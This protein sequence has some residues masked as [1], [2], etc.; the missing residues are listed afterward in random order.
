MHQLK[1][2]R[3]TH[4][5][6]FS[7]LPQVLER[8][9]RKHPGQFFLSDLLTELV[10][11]LQSHY[12]ADQKKL[13][14][15][16]LQQA[17]EILRF[18]LS[19][20]IGEVLGAR[21]HCGA[22]QVFTLSS[23]ADSTKPKIMAWPYEADLVKM[24]Q[25]ATQA[26]WRKGKIFEALRYQL[27]EK[28]LILLAQEIQNVVEEANRSR[29][30]QI[31]RENTRTR[32][33]KKHNERLSQESHDHNNHMWHDISFKVHHQGCYRTVK[34][35][36][37][38]VLYVMPINR[39]VYPAGK[40]KIGTMIPARLESGEV[41][42]LGAI[43]FDL[44]THSQLSMVLS[45]HLDQQIRATEKDLMTTIAPMSHTLLSQLMTI[46]ANTV[47][48][49]DQF[50]VEVMGTVFRL[51]NSSFDGPGLW[52]RFL[53]ED[54]VTHARIKQMT[55]ALLPPMIEL[56]SELLV[57][58]LLKQAPLDRLVETIEMLSKLSRGAIEAEYPFLDHFETLRKSSLN[59]IFYEPSSWSPQYLSLPFF[60]PT[61]LPSLLS[62]PGLTSP[63]HLITEAITQNHGVGLGN[64]LSVADC[65]AGGVI[66]L[67][68]T[69]SPQSWGAISN[70]PS[71]TPSIQGFMGADS[72][73]SG[74]SYTQSPSRRFVRPNHLS[75]LDL[76]AE[77]RKILGDRLKF[78]KPGSCVSCGRRF[79]GVHDLGVGECGV[80][81]AC[82]FGTDWEQEKQN[83][84]TIYSKIGLSSFV[85]SFFNPAV[86]MKTALEAKKEI[87]SR[88][89]SKRIQDQVAVTT[90]TL[91]NNPA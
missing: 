70:T 76:L 57:D 82:E 30:N 55:T 28:Q 63:Q 49:S 45:E 81:F 58:G 3:S 35:I 65:A 1:E 46:D 90:P 83:E 86:L 80:C 5:Y 47:S 72:S 7:R 11:T 9:R 75:G 29:R 41:I 21:V 16:L 61:S 4:D 54:Q 62:S 60:G 40:S 52:R 68:R 17:Q 78:W 44:F 87:S 88:E 19:T 36:A 8:F 84:Q 12:S 69:S 26:A 32:N 15:T 33:P 31:N 22:E 2:S 67:A 91:S 34:A 50:L 64:V 42:V 89:N 43:V 85:A 38:P 71:I 73:F 20:H 23:S 14:S 24:G 48:S 74:A 59:A 6:D 39:R 77:Q 27:E 79:E 13:R 10:K 53:E 51:Q 56:L 25:N 66:S 18:Q 37:T